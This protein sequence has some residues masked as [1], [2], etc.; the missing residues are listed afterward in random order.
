[1]GQAIM[2]VNIMQKIRNPAFPGIPGLRVHVPVIN[3]P[4]FMKLPAFARSIRSFAA[5][6]LAVV[7][8]WAAGGCRK[9]SSSSSA[10]SATTTV[11]D[12]SY[13]LIPANSTFAFTT[14]LTNTAGTGESSPIDTAYCLNKYLV[15]NAAYL[16]FVTATG[17]SA[18]P[19]YWSGG[20]YPSGKA[21]HPVLFVS[22]AD[23]TAYCAWLSSLDTA[24]TFRL[25]TEAEWEN[26]AKG[27]NNYIYP[28]GNTA[29]TS[30]SAGLLSTVFNYNGVITAYL[31]ANAG[32]ELATYNNAS[33]TLYG[34]QLPLDSILSLNAAGYVSGW[35]DH[36]TYTGF[37]Y[38]DIMDSINTRGGN[39]T[40]VGTYTG[41]IST[42]GCYDM[43]GNAFEWTSSLITAVNGAEAG[44][45][46][47]AVRGGSWYST[48]GSCK[49]SYRGEGRSASGYYNTVGFR[50]AA[51]K[52]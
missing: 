4:D 31:L 25:P 9:E 30:Y 41:G 42:Y 14:D 37:V 40:P 29:G 11:P 27:S 20:T 28:W 48:A 33:S 51:V 15:T 3:I 24:W 45:T 1:M 10:S 23:A 36:S 12:T 52:K 32:T 43:A 47:N 8:T 17:R 44:K 7:I 26:A 19:G 38:T 39:T 22:L 5:I 34:T 21:D 16:A 35:V 13:V 2:I 50:V 6:S 18:L 49:T 46:V